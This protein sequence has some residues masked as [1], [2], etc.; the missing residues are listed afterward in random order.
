MLL[1]A[2]RKPR[3][4]IF[5]DAWNK[6]AKLTLLRYHNYH[7]DERTYIKQVVVE[8]ISPALLDKDTHMGIFPH[9]QT[10]QQVQA[11]ALHGKI[12]MSSAPMP[13][14]TYRRRG[15]PGP[16]RFRARTWPVQGQRRRELNKRRLRACSLS[17]RSSQSFGTRACFIY[18]RT[19]ANITN[20]LTAR[21]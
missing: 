5:W 8:S 4:C 12:T 16:K 13:R 17:D 10:R 1:R 6:E 2:L 19:L 9:D 21:G 15:D 3:G 14:G 18:L 11:T 20:T 7:K